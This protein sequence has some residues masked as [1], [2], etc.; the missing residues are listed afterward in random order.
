MTFVILDNYV[1]SVVAETGVILHVPLKRCCALCCFETFIMSRCASYYFLLEP[2]VFLG[3]SIFIHSLFAHEPVAWILLQNF[4]R[5]PRPHRHATRIH[6]CLTFRINGRVLWRE[7]Y[8]S[9]S[10]EAPRRRAFLF[11]LSWRRITLCFKTLIR[12]RCEL[13]RGTFISP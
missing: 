10:F 11:L 1:N 9:A 7:C 3:S 13:S 4:G 6:F 5:R 12:G 2:I 8:R